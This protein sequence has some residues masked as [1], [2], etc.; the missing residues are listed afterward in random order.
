MERSSAR[1]VGWAYLTAKGG[2]ASG[3]FSITAAIPQYFLRLADFDGQFFE[4]WPSQAPFGREEGTDGQVF[5]NLSSLVNMSP[6]I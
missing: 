1:P 6:P 5:L 2:K 3:V 4:N